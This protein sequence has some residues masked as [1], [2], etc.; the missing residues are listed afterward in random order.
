MD[1]SVRG[2]YVTV[3]LGERL[4]IGACVAVIFQGPKGNA[5]DELWLVTKGLIVMFGGMEDEVFYPNGGI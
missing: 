1:D 4:V 3:V 2:A 5:T